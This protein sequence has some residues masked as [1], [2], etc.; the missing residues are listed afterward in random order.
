MQVGNHD[1]RDID[2][3]ELQLTDGTQQSVFFDCSESFGKFPSAG[4]F[5]AREKSPEDTLP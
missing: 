3:F 5:S 1:G 2:T 4:L